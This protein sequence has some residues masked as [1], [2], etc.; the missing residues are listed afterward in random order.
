MGS[1]GPVAFEQLIAL[2]DE[3]AALVRAG[4]PLER[5]LAEMGR[6]L[7][8]RAGR[9]AE[10]L[11]G[12]MSAGES[13]QQILASQPQAF[14]PVWR[15]VV[16]A[17]LRSGRLSV[18]LE[19]LS[20]T[21]RRVSE[22]RKMVGAAL[23]YPLVVLAL[24]YAMFVF[25]ATHFAPVTLGAYE[26]LTGGSDWFLAGLV[27]L[28]QTAQWW[29]VW[30]PLVMAILLGVWWHRSRRAAWSPPPGKARGP[31]RWLSPASA[32]GTVLRDER[33]A[34]F[35]EL[36][37]LLLEQR[38]PL[39]QALVLAADASGDAAIRQAARKMA[40]RLQQ[41][42]VLARREDLP[43]GFPPLLGWLLASGAQQPELSR[44]LSRTAATYR[45]RAARAAVWT[46][47]YLP[48]ALTVL[49]G[50]TATLVQ[51]LVTFVPV[52]KLLYDLTRQVY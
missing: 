22:L 12:R 44:M 18:A 3:M 25:A 46:S 35:A 26:D 24:A 43:P 16:E 34:A 32:I 37:S 4:I 19:S 7:P 49:V 8:G 9:L 27:W 6:D 15:A 17:G 52:W 48:I 41:G 29:A 1:A 39:Q 28:G 45:E 36:L 30:L 51:G 11:A 38:V 23:L 14:P 2:N 13:L 47:V 42:D 33:M 50:G 10:M 21:A 31:S 20:A 40:D 5:G